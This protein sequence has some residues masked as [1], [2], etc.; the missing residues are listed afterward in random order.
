MSLPRRLRLDPHEQR[1]RDLAAIHAAASSLGLDTSD[2]SPS[3]AYRTIVLVQGGEGVSSAAALTAAGRRRVRSYLEQQLG[4][5]GD[6]R[7]AMSQREWI[8]QLW[9][10]LGEAGALRDPSPGG[11]ARFVQREHGVDAVEWLSGAQASQVI[12]AL[13]AWLARSRGKS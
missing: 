3:S 8:E 13:K 12:E 11:L 1:R 2:K 10:R 4:G 7:R 6:A 5:A 9:R